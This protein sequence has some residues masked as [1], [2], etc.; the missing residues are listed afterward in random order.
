MFFSS[1]NV[2]YYI[3]WL[4]C[5]H[6]QYVTNQREMMTKRLNFEY[7]PENLEKTHQ[8]P[9][10][11]TKRCV[12]FATNYYTS[13]KLINRISRFFGL[14]IILHNNNQTKISIFSLPVAG[15]EGTVA[16]SRIEKLLPG[17]LT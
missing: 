10:V 8:N 16:L 9:C 3:E 6:F 11:Y 15:K 17:L 1:I 2:A 14:C 5:V 4:F 7:H 12:F 13:C